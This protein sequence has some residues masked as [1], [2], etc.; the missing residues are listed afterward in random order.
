MEYL[1][2]IE[3]SKRWEISSIR[4]AVLCEQVRIAWV[5]KKGKTWLIPYD[6]E[7]PVDARKTIIVN[8]VYL[9]VKR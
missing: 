1:I 2:T 8:E 5:V 4:I 3:M 9:N 7:K 6:S